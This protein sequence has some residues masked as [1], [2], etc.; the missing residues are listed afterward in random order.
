[1]KKKNVLIVISI[2]LLLFITGTFLLIGFFN[3]ASNP[4]DIVTSETI[5]L[6]N[7]KQ[8]QFEEFG[9]EDFTCTG[10]TYDSLNKSFWIADNGA[11]D[12]SEEVHPRLI[13][14]SSDFKHILNTIDLKEI[15]DDSFNLQGLSY[16]KI[17]DAL[18]I[19]TGDYI[20][21]LNKE[22]AVLSKISM[23]EYS[24]YKSNG[25]AINGNDIWVLCYRK[26]LLKFNRQGNV[27]NKYN[28]N[29]Q[30]Q[31]QIYFFND[32]LYCTVGADYSGDNNYVFT[33]NPN[34]EELINKYIVIGSHSV[35]GIVI[36]DN[37]MYIA[38]DGKFHKD[39]VGS[40]YISEYRI[41]E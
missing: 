21:E 17:D 37:I 22:G 5:T 6:M 8:I 20:I 15:M 3:G 13:E 10:M 28:F 32:L 19:A 14:I 18:W 25:I 1:M 41:K 33:F 29:Y 11:S 40:S 30:D 12:A 24:E 31:D 36:K 35:E 23:A 27:V 4:V 2:I 39:L 7:E 26:Y 16:D 9:A 38:N 34:T